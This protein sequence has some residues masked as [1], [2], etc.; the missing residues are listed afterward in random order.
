M[1]H[2]EFR[3]QRLMQVSQYAIPEKIFFSIFQVDEKLELARRALDF[4]HTYHNVSVVSSFAHLT[5][6]IYSV[7]V[8]Q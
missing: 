6:I 2:A 7:L 5:D 8:C 4:G 3:L 1:I